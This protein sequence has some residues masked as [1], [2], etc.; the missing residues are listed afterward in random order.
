MQTLSRDFYMVV[1]GIHGFNHLYVGRQPDS[2]YRLTVMIRAY[3]TG[4]PDAL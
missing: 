2:G 3:R 4:A 1:G